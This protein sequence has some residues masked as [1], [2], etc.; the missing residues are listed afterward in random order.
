MESH[1]NQQHEVHHHNVA[2]NNDIM[3]HSK[4]N[5]GYDDAIS[6]GW[7]GHDHHKMMIAGFKKRFWVTCTNLKEAL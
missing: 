6:M 3:D 1:P 2:K 7:A 4:M 5:H